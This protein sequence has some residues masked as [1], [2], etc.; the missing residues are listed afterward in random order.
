M[1]SPEQGTVSRSPAYPAARVIARKV[2]EH[3]IRHLAATSA[4]AQAPAAADVELLVDAAFWASLRREEGFVPKI[5]FALLPPDRAP[6]P[7]LL[8][9]P[10]PVSAIPLVRVA[11]AVERP[12]IHL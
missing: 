2:Q 10:I 7:L 9:Q 1:G 4:D 6:Q 5:S 12:G 11:P 3:F 8:E